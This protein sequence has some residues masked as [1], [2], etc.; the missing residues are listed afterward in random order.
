MGLGASVCWC[1]RGRIPAQPGSVAISNRNTVQAI[2]S[3]SAPQSSLRG[4]RLGIRASSNVGSISGAEQ[5]RINIFETS[6]E[7]ATELTDSI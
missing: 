5:S 3:L 4:N 1:Y 6:A 2:R 7:H